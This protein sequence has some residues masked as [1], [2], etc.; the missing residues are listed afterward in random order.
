VLIELLKARSAMRAVN[1]GSMQELNGAKNSIGYSVRPSEFGT[2]LTLSRA[3][4]LITSRCSPFY[5]FLGI[6]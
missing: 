4:L 5:W 3:A 2:D 1:F 6:Y